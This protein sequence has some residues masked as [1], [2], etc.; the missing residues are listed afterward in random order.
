M[1]TM[2]VDGVPTNAPNVPPGLDKTT[3]NAS[4]A[5]TIPSLAMGIKKVWFVVSPLAQVNVPLVAV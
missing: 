2:A 1:F 4:C 3:L 5:S